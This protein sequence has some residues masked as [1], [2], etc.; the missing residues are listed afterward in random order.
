MP[1]SPT[2]T[3]ISEPMTCCDDVWEKAYLRFETAKEETVKFQKRLTRLGAS[4]WKKDSRV[5]EIFSGR[6]NGLKALSSL[7]FTRLEGVDLSERLLKQYDG[8]GDLYVCDCRKLPFPDQSR[9]IIIVQGGLHHL[10]NVRQHVPEVFEEVSRVLTPHGQFIA[11]EPWHTPFL[12]FVHS[13]T[14]NRLLRRA[15]PKLDALSIMIDRER[16]TYEAW[17]NENEFILKQ[18][19]RVFQPKLCQARWGKLLF[20]GGK[21]SSAT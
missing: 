8:A 14:R 2:L 1:K 12:S 19:R 13:L 16:T 7:G 20:V 4:A 21:K 15:W 9:D 6:C 5:V 18:L 10:P 3:R 17:L 11:V